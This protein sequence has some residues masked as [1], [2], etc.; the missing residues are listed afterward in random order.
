MEPT[1]QQQEEEPTTGEQY[2]SIQEA[3][4]VTDA[5]NNAD[6]VNKGNGYSIITPNTADTTTTCTT[7]EEGPNNQ[8]YPTSTNNNDKS[9][10][11]TESS[12]K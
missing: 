2:E 5:T 1:A 8:S 4:I 11:E 6:S 12:N 10:K 3:G 7:V 9:Y